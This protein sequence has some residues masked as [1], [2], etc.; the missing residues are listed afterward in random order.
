MPFRLFGPDHLAALALT[1][2]VGTALI[3]LIRRD[4]RGRVA[5]GV[6]FVL[7]GLLLAAISAY[8][9][10]EGI[11]RPLSVLDL[12]PLHLCDFLIF[13][14]AYALLT[15]RAGASELLYF[16]SG[17]TLLA[18][19]T[20]N[21][22]AGFPHPY[23]F[24]FFGLHG[25]VVVAAVVVTFGCGRTPR[26]GSA[27]RVFAWTLAYAALVGCVN[28]LFDTNFLFLCGKPAQ[29][30]LLDWLGPWPL[31]LATTALLALLLF[32]GMAWPFRRRT[33]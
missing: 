26:E 2:L 22:A 15:L 4:P 9:L 12:L 14:A 8:L 3:G 13:V 21:L 29:P 28:L 32:H 5:R 33:A 23:F 10:N 30:T 25:L 6:R 16:W 31:Y 27:W 11:R 19:V 1:L 20:P 7:A 24:V 18:M 17:G